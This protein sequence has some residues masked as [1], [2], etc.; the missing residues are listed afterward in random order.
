MRDRRGIRPAPSRAQLRSPC[1]FEVGLGLTAERQVVVE[2]NREPGHVGI[3]NAPVSRVPRR[4]A[5]H[6][7]LRRPHRRSDLVARRDLGEDVE[8]DGPT[9][10]A[11]MSSRRWASGDSL[12]TRSSTTSLSAEVRTC[13]SAPRPESRSM[14]R[15]SVTKKGLPAVWATITSTSDSG[16]LAVPSRSAEATRSVTQARSR[17]PSETDSTCSIRCV[18]VSNDRN[19]SV[20]SVSV[21]R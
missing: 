17:P 16:S 13:W 8:A 5:R 2:P 21:S 14:P 12:R 11:A 10:T 15:S 7:R 6:V 9:S 3:G 19:E 20:S 18:S 1:E 4:E